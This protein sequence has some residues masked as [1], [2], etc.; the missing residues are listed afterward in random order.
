MIPTSETIIAE[1][2]KTGTTDWQITSPDQSQIEG[3]ASAV[4]LAPGADLSLYVN[5]D[6]SVSTFG[7][8]IYRMGYY[9]GFGGRLMAEQLNLPGIAQQTPSLDQATWMAECQWQASYTTL[10]PSD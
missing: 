3:Y 9:Q 6:P 1:N 7:L 4:S 5:C 10:V 2:Q 8:Q